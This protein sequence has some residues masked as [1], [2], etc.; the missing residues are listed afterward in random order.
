M[1]LFDK[2]RGSLMDVFVWCLH[3]SSQYPSGFQRKDDLMLLS[4]KMFD[5][6]NSLGWVKKLSESLQKKWREKFQ[7]RSE[8]FKKGK[9]PI[10][11]SSGC[12]YKRMR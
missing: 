7:G 6:F 3:T 11:M 2:W 1:W 9:F 10:D 5:Y 12:Y 8:A 4:E